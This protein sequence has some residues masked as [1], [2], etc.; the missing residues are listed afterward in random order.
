VAEHGLDYA[1][2][3]IGERRDQGRMVCLQWGTRT[4]DTHRVV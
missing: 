4:F 3:V 1:D 2:V